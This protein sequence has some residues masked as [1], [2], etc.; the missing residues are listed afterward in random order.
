MKLNCS[1]CLLHFIL[2]GS[3]MQFRQERLAG[4]G[5]RRWWCLLGC[6]RFWSS[7][8]EKKKSDSR[9]IFEFA[10]LSSPGPVLIPKRTFFEDT[11]CHSQRARIPPCENWFLVIFEI[12]KNGICFKKNPWNLFIS[13]QEEVIFGLDFFN[14]LRPTVSFRPCQL[15]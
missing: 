1:N 10:P 5:G 15:S 2:S 8:D 11:Y 6:K 3:D 9:V 4:P 7:C 13:F 12:A 14:I